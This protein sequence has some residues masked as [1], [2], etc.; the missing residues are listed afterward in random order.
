[1]EAD[2][3]DATGL[4]QDFEA[5]CWVAIEECRHL[6]TPYVPTVWI[7]M[8]RRHG[9]AEAARKLLVSGD[10]QY[11]FTRLIE[12]GRYDLTV[13]WAVLQPQWAPLFSP[14]H[15]ESATLRLEQVQVQP[16]N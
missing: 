2:V 10:I 9:A 15:R 6:Q 13:E 12:Q 3:S 8:I 7:N 14:L 16:P 4:E 11:G 1:L 5:A